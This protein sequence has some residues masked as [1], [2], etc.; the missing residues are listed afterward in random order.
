MRIRLPASR[1]PRQVAAAIRRETLVRSS[2]Q[3]TRSALRDAGRAGDPVLL[4]PFLGEI[5]YELLYWIPFLRRELRLAGISPERATVVTRGGAGIWYSD[6]AAASLDILELIPP[7]TFLPRLEERR[8]R[9]GDA[10]QLLVEDLDRELLGEAQARLGKQVVV[11]PSL[12]FAALRGLWF[13]GLPVEKGLA[14][15]DYMSLEVEAEPLPSL[16]SD[17]VAVKPYFN[18]C[19]PESPRTRVLI[20]SLVERIASTVDVVLLSTGLA[21][22]DHEEWNGGA[23]RVHRIDHLL[24]PEDNLA[25]QTRVITS[26]RGLA[27]TYGGF[28]YLGPFLG[29]PTLTFFENAG[30]V[31]LHLEVLERALP[32]ADHVHVPLDDQAALEAFAVRMAA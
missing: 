20:S 26:A 31:P 1:T 10:K 19:V 8:R 17:Y 28:S 13:T 32:D 21:L 27:A 14:R 3:R 18:D 9:S 24:R 22:D 2:V 11:H 6:F 12:M 29:I 7:E 25:V 15:L 23:E 16:P 4:G 30:T 5:G